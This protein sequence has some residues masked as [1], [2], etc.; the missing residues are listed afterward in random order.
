ME[1]MAKF[2]DAIN[3]FLGV[4]KPSDLVFH[5]VFIVICIAMLIYSIIKGWRFF[6][7]GIYFVLAGAI[8]FHYLYPANSSNLGELIKFIGAMGVVGLIGVYF[9]FIRD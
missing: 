1:S 4:E 9:G 3:K 6:A 5:P 8:V 7:V 2:F